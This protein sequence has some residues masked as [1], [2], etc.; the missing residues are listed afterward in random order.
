MYMC[1]EISGKVT[2]PEHIDED[3]LESGTAVKAIFASLKLYSSQPELSTLAF[4]PGLATARDTGCRSSMT[5][6][7]SIGRPSNSCSNNPESLEQGTEM[8]FHPASRKSID[9]MDERQKD[10][11]AG[12]AFFE[13]RPRLKGPMKRDN[14]PSSD[15]LR[16][17]E[18]ATR[19]LDIHPNLF[20]DCSIFEHSSIRGGTT[21][22]PATSAREERCLH[23]EG[24]ELL[25][26]RVR[27]WPGEDLLRDVDASGWAS[28]FPTMAEMWLWRAS[29]VYITFCGG[30]W[31]ILL[32]AVRKYRPL[33]EFWDRWADGGAKWW[34]NLLVGPPVVL[35]G[36][37]F[38]VARGFM[39]MEA[40][41][42][43]RALP[44]GAYDTPSWSQVFPHF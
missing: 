6:P 20:K 26:A 29:A 2:S 44:A 37:S 38:F 17:W 27:N 4:C 23:F 35:C 11:G 43:I 14:T 25:A 15:A 21:D 3:A 28:H 13:R 16:R 10:E 8:G 42:S 9:M 12:A 5:W 22:N 18:L 24:E 40:F 41:L 31:I 1:S 30:L 39:V 33:N 19:A 7:L 32:T 34:Q 36:L